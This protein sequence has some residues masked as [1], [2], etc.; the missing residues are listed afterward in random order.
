MASIITFVP[1]VHEYPPAYKQ[2]QIE[3][4][5]N[6]KKLQTLK[7]SLIAETLLR[8]FFP[9]YVTKILNNGKERV[10]ASTLLAIKSN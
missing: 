4:N 8:M 2:A 5:E 10:T 3:T 9:K 7:K 6:K 1:N